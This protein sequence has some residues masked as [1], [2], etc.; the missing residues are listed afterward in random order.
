MLKRSFFVLAFVALIVGGCAPAKSVNQAGEYDR[1][2]VEAPAQPPALTSGKTALE[3]ESI[4]TSSEDDSSRMVIRNA[5]MDIVVE[6]PAAVMEDIIHLAEEF[7][8][9][10][11]NSQ[12]YQ[13]STS[14]GAQVQE[15]YITIRVPVER[16]DEARERIKGYVKDPKEDILSDSISGQDISKEYTDL[17]SQLR[18][19]EDAAEQLRKIMDTATKPEDVLK[20][21]NELKKVNERIELLKGQI[22]YYDEAAAMS[23]ISVQIHAEE[24][25]E[26]V[27]VAGWNPQGVARDALQTLIDI[28]QWIAKAAIWIVI[29]CLPVA[30]PVGLVVYFIVRGVQRARRKKEAQQSKEAES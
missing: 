20:V 19:E 5:N 22:K 15:A 28:Y 16:L 8:G 18:N 14:N 26:P 10:V 30:I 21:F 25:I 4:D 7:G 24:T 17:Q 12:L 2:M 3:G 29:T 23:A 27:S 1:G 13:S 11:V 6:D 9:F